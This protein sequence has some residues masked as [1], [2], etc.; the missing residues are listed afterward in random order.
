MIKCMSCRKA[1]FNPFWGEYK[2]SIYRHVLYYP[3]KV[4]DCHEYKEGTPTEAKGYEEYK[5]LQ[6]N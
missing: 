2:C 3:S 5:E 4:E 1:I 6:N